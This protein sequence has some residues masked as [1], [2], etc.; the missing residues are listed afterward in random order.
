MAEAPITADEFEARVTGQVMS[1][2]TGGMPFGAEEYLDGRRVRWSAL[3]GSCSEGRWFVAEG[4]VCFVYEDVAT[5][6]CW[7]YFDREGGLLAR[8]E[9]REDPALYEVTKSAAPLYCAGPDVG[10]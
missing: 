7:S 10:V 6:Q 2:L 4:S 3:D 5:P 1:Y 8:F 9:N